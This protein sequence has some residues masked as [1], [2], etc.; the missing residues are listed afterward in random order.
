MIQ[1]PAQGDLEI[2]RPAFQ[3]GDEAYNPSTPLV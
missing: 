3:I 1:S 2:I